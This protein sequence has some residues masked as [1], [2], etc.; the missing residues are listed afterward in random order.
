M[1]YYHDFP[2]EWRGKLI[3]RNICRN[4]GGTPLKKGGKI[5]RQ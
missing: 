5:H 3:K 1:Y 4:P 2:A